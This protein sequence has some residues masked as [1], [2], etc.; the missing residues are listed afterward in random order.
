MM[1][2]LYPEPG[3]V[4]DSWVIIL[5]CVLGGLVALPLLAWLLRRCILARQHRKV[6]HGGVGMGRN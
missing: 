4:V 3:K 5:A 2:Q 1:T 6:G